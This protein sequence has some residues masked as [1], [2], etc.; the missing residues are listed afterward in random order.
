MSSRHYRPDIDGLRAVAVSFVLIF[1]AFPEVLPGGFIG[2]DVFFVISGFL[3]TG[4]I[5]AELEAGSFSIANFYFRRVRRIFPALITVLSATLILG[6]FFFLPNEF[7]SLG[8]N[9]YAGALFFPNLMLLSEVGYF[10]TAAQLKPL[11]HLWSLGIEEQFYFAFP[12]FLLLLWPRRRLLLLGILAVAT[13]SFALN[14]EVLKTNPSAAFYL[15]FTRAWELMVGATLAM[16][17]VPAIGSQIRA[18]LG[19]SL[20]AVA[21]FY[22][23]SKTPY[24]GW[25]ALLPVGGTALLVTSETSFLNRIVLSARPFVFVGLISYPLYLWHWPL[26]SFFGIL[27]EQQPSPELR[28]ATL[29]ASAAIAYLTYRFVELPLR[30]GAART[31]KLAG[32]ATAMV[33]IC[34]CGVLIVQ[35]AG[36]PPRLSSAI[37]SAGIL[38]PSFGSLQKSNCLID[39]N[40]TTEFPADCIDAKAGGPLL[41][42]WG[43]STAGALAPGFRKLQETQKFRLGQLVTSSCWPILGYDVPTAPNCRKM[44]D[45]ALVTIE[46]SKPDVVILEGIWSTAFEEIGKTVAK[47]KAL[48]VPKVIV[49]GRVPVWN[50]DLP[51]AYLKY[52]LLHGETMPARQDRSRVDSDWT[53]NKIKEQVEAAG[54]VFISTYAVICNSESC[55]TRAGDNSPH[56]VASDRLHLTEAGAIFVVNELAKDVF[57]DIN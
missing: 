22:L 8:K 57:S 20:I 12:F 29:L 25:N 35:T 7:I 50:L 9:V 49:M 38:N 13:A 18:L 16:T 30:T 43:D 52:F 3:I 55:L 32:L 10:D 47:L 54:G 19:A 5:V 27:S 15:P 14:I 26:L 48:N 44:N 4:I 34:V 17:S 2:V 39:S 42:L 37:A 28:G 56:I 33:S 53:D 11:L 21:A 23:D 24:P 31:A 46:R 6:W 36:Y 40:A 1:H 41:L 45:L 51:T